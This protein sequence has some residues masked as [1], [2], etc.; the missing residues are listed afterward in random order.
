MFIWNSSDMRVDR[1][2][3]LVMVLRSRRRTTAAE[4][5]TELEVSE[6]T[7]LR[8]IAALAAAGVPVYSE[9]GRGG[10]FA[11]V[12]GWSTDLSGLSG[13]EARALLVA[14]SSTL[15]ELGL[16][17]AFATGLAKV[18]SSLPEEH[19]RTAEGEAA[20]IL[21]VSEGYVGGREP[22]P[23]LAVAQR[24]VTAGRRLQISYRHK[25][26]EAPTRRTVDPAG[27]VC[28]GGTW[29][30]L[31]AHRRQRRTFRVARISAAR[32]LDA[33]ADLA[34]LPGVV[35]WWERSRQDFSARSPAL[36]AVVLADQAAAR[37]LRERSR[38]VAASTSLKDGR[39]QLTLEFADKAH[40]IGV[41]WPQADGIE[42]LSPVSVR[43]ELRRRAEATCQRHC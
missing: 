1:L 31:A 32:I 34:G 28:A 13:T 36:R 26:A 4:L 37:L 41:L 12:G 9:R 30:L 23:C 8:D 5:A 42:V 3:A 7:V 15:A 18:L 22:V 11:L 19:R 33:P 20:R 35:E 25:S 10:G 21:V 16:G 29:Y 14:G 38:A 2:L 27:L 39:T 17:P 24:A 6:R 40:A 43:A